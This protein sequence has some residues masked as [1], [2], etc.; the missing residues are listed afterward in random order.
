VNERVERA[1]ETI[2]DRILL[3]VVATL[4]RVHNI[5]PVPETIERFRQVVLEG[6]REVALASR[7]DVLHPKQPGKPDQSI[8]VTRPYPRRSKSKPPPPGDQT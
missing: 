5:R 8:I 3:T 1:I 4:K 6:L 2:T 7:L